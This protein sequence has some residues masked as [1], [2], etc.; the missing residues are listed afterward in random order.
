MKQ[1]LEGLGHP[2]A[3]RAKEG[4]RALH[5]AHRATVVPADP[6]RLTGSVDL[7]ACLDRVAAYD[8]QAKWDYGVGFLEPHGATRCA[9][10]I[11]VHNATPGDVRAVSAKLRTLR[12]WLDDDGRSLAG[13]TDAA[14]R[15]LGGTP[16]RWIAVG[17]TS[18]VA[19]STCFRAAA[20]AGLGFP[21]RR[22]RIP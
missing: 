20:G 17:P 18:L 2:Y 21:Q 13:P 4:L 6:R 16:F 14:R 7:E 12:R 10:W 19:S 22:L 3:Q 5:R 1:E 11:E 8:D 9:V 15:V